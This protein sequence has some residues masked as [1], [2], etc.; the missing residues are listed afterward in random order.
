[1]IVNDQTKQPAQVWTHDGLYVGGFFDHRADDGRAAGFYQVHGDDNQGA[2][3]VKASN[4]KVYWLMPYQGHN[5]LYEISGWDNWQRQ[6]GPVTRPEYPATQL[7]PG[8]GLT[9][10]YFQ[11]TNLIHEAAEAP[12]YYE[13]F[14][15]EPHAGKVAAPYKAVWSGFVRPP[16]TDLFRFA[17]LLGKGEQVTVWIDGKIVYAAGTADAA[18]RR[19]PL[20]GGKRHRIRV[21]YV[22]PD[23][24]AELKLLWSSRIID[25]ARLSDDILYPAP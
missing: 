25:P 3:I 12:I 17:S 24:R 8:T 1:V 11:G 2:T 18:N 15:G 5:R 6:S 21:E 10:K 7:D 9:A 19:I 13:P 4:G 14:G 20:T 23:G 16:V 22:N